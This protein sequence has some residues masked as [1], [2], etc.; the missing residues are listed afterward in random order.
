MRRFLFALPA[1]ALLAGCVGTSAD[2]PMAPTL[3]EER[4]QTLL[5]PSANAK[6]SLPAPLYDR[7]QGLPVAGK[8]SFTEV[9]ID[10]ED[11]ASP[12][13]AFV[14]LGTYSAD[15]FT[16]VNPSYTGPDVTDAFGSPESGNTAYYQGSAALINNHEYTATALTKDGGGAFNVESIDLAELTPTSDTTAVTFT[17]TR[18]DGSTVSAT[19]TTDGLEGFETFTFDG[20]TD[21][22]SLSWSQDYPYHQFDN[23]VLTF[24]VVDPPPKTLTVD[25]PADKA[26]CKNEG[27]NT[28]GFK[29]QGQCVRFVETGEDSRVH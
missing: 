16:L 8:T 3:H 4:A 10:F 29:N 18:A 1:A 2:S 12:G 15:G 20:F 11:L 5:P 22:V 7:K 27:W 28:F 25:D 24:A 21:L 17:G 19:F 26:A 9:V 23:I 6:Y 13:T 14:F